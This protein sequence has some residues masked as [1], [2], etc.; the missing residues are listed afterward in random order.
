MLPRAAVKMTCSTNDHAAISSARA[1][2]T[3]GITPLMVFHQF[4]EPPPRLHSR[5]GAVR[6]SRSLPMQACISS[7]SNQA[8]P[9][10]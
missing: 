3:T 2:P 5:S 7:G 9:H 8:L 10:V 1:P 4:A 6:A